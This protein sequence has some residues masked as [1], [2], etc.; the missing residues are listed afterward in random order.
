MPIDFTAATTRLA[1]VAFQD[2][3]ANSAG[4]LIEAALLN[5]MVAARAADARTA[6]LPTLWF[7]DGALAVRVLTATRADPALGAL[8]IPGVTQFDTGLGRWWQAATELPALIV[9]V[10]RMLG[11]ID[12]S[13]ARYSSPT[14][15][16]FNPEQRTVFDLFGV[17]AGLMSALT[18]AN[19][20]GGAADRLNSAMVTSATM[21]LSPAPGAATQAGVGAGGPP[22][23]V[24]PAESVLLAAV[25]TVAAAPPTIGIVVRGL[26]IRTRLAVI[27]TLRSLETMVRQW[28]AETYL[29]VFSAL[30][31][32]AHSLL[33]LVRALQH[34]V[35]RYVDAS[36]RL[37]VALGGA[38]G[39]A[40]GGFV[41]QV[42]HFLRGI[43]I[44]MAL[45]VEVLA[46]LGFNWSEL[47]TPP[48]VDLTSAFP[49][50]GNSLF[51]AEVRREVGA[52]IRRTDL[53]VR[54][55]LSIGF[56]QLAD[57]LD[58]TAAN[59]GPPA[60]TPYLGVITPSQPTDTD[61][62]VTALLPLEPRPQHRGPVAGAFES[63]IADRRTWSASTRAAV[64]AG[65]AGT[66][67]AALDGYAREIAQ[68]R[69]DR[70]PED[71][72]ETGQPP[73]TPTATSPHITRRHAVVGHVRV[74]RVLIRVGA[75]TDDDDLDR[76]AVA[77]AGTVRDA[78]LHSAP[79]FPAWGR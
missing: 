2:R 45:L 31:G 40:V 7:H 48:T 66:L 21:L 76:V 64:A 14:P 74:P 58:T 55:Q 36:I 34:V 13:I 78:Y 62:T 52:I 26:A 41:S 54:T 32:G 49:D 12:S 75:P 11:A 67:I 18:E 33:L 23:P 22:L 43:V 44:V 5:R 73:T 68:L 53:D 4:R 8:A 60:S 65:A 57:G 38:I 39:T 6:E 79:Q 10:D 63:W 77:L 25:L 19:R 17:A 35:G 20:S 3:L 51:G 24:D 9:A 29:A 50:I 72:D 46:F 59:F 42:A 61:R 47:P 27:D 1:A 70:R 30:R 15:G 28:I 71:A 56:G 69:R 37:V 16:L